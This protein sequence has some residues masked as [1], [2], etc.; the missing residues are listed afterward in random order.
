LFKKKRV[1]FQFLSAI[2]PL[3]ADKSPGM[4]VQGFYGWIMREMTFSIHQLSYPAYRQQ[5]GINNPFHM[6]QNACQV[7]QTPDVA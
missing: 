2:R 3:K 5:P 1:F 4:P 6:K 7:V